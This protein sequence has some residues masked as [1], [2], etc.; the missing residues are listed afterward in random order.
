MK[1]RAHVI[2]TGRVQGISFRYY[3]QRKASALG[4]CGYVRNL[5]NGN[6]EIVAEGEEATIQKL[7]DWARTGPPS[8]EVTELTTRFSEPTGEFDLFTVRY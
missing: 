8:A 7:I 2:V 1:K 6:V 5:P 3:T 4:L